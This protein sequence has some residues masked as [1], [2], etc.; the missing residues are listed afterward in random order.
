MARVASADGRAGG[1]PSPARASGPCA[2]AAWVARPRVLPCRAI[3][4]ATTRSRGPRARAAGGVGA[5]VR[6]G[7]RRSRCSPRCGLRSWRST[8]G[9]S[10]ARRAGAR[11]CVGIRV[12]PAPDG[13]LARGRG[14]DPRRRAPGRD[15]PSAAGWVGSCG[16]RGRGGSGAPAPTNA[17]SAR[18]RTAGRLRSSGS[19]VSPRPRRSWS[20]FI[21]RGAHQQSSPS[22][23]MIAG[24]RNIRTTVASSSSAISRPNARYFI[25]TRSENTNAPAT[26]ARTSAAP[27]ISRPVVRGADPDRL[28]GGHAALAGLHHA[29]HQEHF[30]VGRQTPDHRDD[31]ADHRRHQRL[32]GVVHQPGAVPVDEH[33]RQHAHRRAERERAHH[34]GLDRQ[35]HRSERQE[36]QDRGRGDQQRPPS[37]AACRTGCGY[38]PAPA[39]VCRRPTR[40]CPR[41][42]GIARSSSIFLAR[43]VAVLEAVLDDADRRI[44]RRARRGT[45]VP[46]TSSTGRCS[47]SMNPGT[48][49]ALLRDLGDLRVGDR[50]AVVVLDHQRQ[51]L[52]AEAGEG[53]VELLLR[54]AHRVVR[55]QVL[56]ADAAEG[57]LPRAG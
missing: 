38:C 42:G 41:G 24:T 13:P 21:Q 11:A 30:V 37:T 34:R 18:S 48:A 45:G 12:V 44:L 4:P 10:A 55:R 16:G 32:R 46:A 39:R 23:F 29:G 7:G 26:T 6:C 52:G 53:L 56:L 50:L 25:I 22:S 19:S 14:R 40:S 28:G 43:V 9:W 17:S 51:R 49:I 27:V 3:R 1:P 35:H 15:A 31:Q 36:H 5:L 54:L 57:E 20:R 8:A 47:A 33:P 2:G